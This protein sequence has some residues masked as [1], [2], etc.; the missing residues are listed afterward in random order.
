MPGPPSVQT[1]TATVVRDGPS[2]YVVLPFDPKAAFGAV[3]A[4]VVVTIGGYTFRSRVVA[5]GGP[6][7]VVMRESHRKAAGLEGGET[8]TARVE[9]DAAP[10]TVAATADLL[11]ALKAVPGALDAWKASSYTHQR[12]HVEAIEG[13]KKPETRARRVAAAVAMVAAKAAARPAPRT[14]DSLAKKR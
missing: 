9:L 7:C 13:A 4:P 8:V 2:C 14:A 11:R 6:V 12:E 10:R 1:F 3:R 5:M